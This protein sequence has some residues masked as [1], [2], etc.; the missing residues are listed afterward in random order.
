MRE[1][2]LITLTQHILNMTNGC[3]CLLFFRP[4]SLTLL[5]RGE[6]TLHWE[7]SLY[8]QCMK[9]VLQTSMV[10]SAFYCI[11]NLVFFRKKLFAKIAS[12]SLSC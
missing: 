2:L 4:G 8:L 11:L 10:S 12:C 1:I 7:S 3:D 6:P 9:V 5:W